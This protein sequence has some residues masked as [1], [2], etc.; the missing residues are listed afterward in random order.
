MK[1]VGGEDRQSPR[2]SRQSDERRSSAKSRASGKP[3]SLRINVVKVE[4]INRMS[5]RR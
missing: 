2:T 4:N 1:R 3:P 5:G